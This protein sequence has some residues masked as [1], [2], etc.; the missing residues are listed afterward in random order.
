[1]KDEELGLTKTGWIMFKISS[2]HDGTANQ[3]YTGNKVD[4]LK[5]YFRI[6]KSETIKKFIDNYPVADMNIHKHMGDE[7]NE[8]IFVIPTSNSRNVYAQY[9]RNYLNKENL[10]FVESNGKF[11]NYARSVNLGISEAMKTSPDKI[12]ICNDDIEFI[13]SID[14]LKRVIKKNSDVIAMT[15][16][17]FKERN[18]Y[19]GETFSVFES[20]SRVSIAFDEVRYRAHLK[21][22]HAISYSLL[23]PL[24]RKNIRYQVKLDPIGYNTNLNFLVKLVNFSDFGIFDSSVFKSMRFEEAYING[25]EDYDFVMKLNHIGI[26]IKKIKPIIKSLGGKTLGHHFERALR[27]MLNEITLS[28][29]IEKLM[30]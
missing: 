8:M 12:V 26:N 3:L 16:S 30:Q 19:H 23:V 11:F 2:S 27:N 5:F 13:D 22:K 29:Q 24:L 9:L 21:F 15:P 14:M 1:M 20:K 7:T 10:I 6:H 25:C 18:V 4:L 17:Q 28:N